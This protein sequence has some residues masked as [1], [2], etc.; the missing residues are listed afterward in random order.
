[1][2][3]DQTSLERLRN[4]TF[5]SSRRG[6][7]KRE[8]EKFLNRLADWLETGGGDEARSDTVRRELE[9]VGQRTGAILS[10]AEES[11]Q[12]IR[13][14][15]EEEA[16]ATTPRAKDAADTT[17]KEAEGYASDSRTAADK[18]S[19]QTRRDADGYAENTR[20]ASDEQA[21]SIK[22][23]SEDE[24]RERVETAK[25][26]AKRIVEEGVKR[27]RDIEAVISDLVRR[28]DE[29][30]RETERLGDQLTTAVQD[31]KPPAG[32]DPFATPDELDPAHRGEPGA[33][34]DAG[35]EAEVT[36][37]GGGEA[38]SKKKAGSRRRSSGTQVK[39]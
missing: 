35:E 23:K 36:A 1:M 9:R 18:Y 33:A 21:A 12:A 19:D 20:Q 24:A 5:P 27:R 3:V 17:R 38:Q 10:Q 22:A 28:R 32:G 37:E 26:Q 6:Y 4:A 34:A 7:D 39:A 30:L 25:A 8:V 15:A 11:A 31:H 2:S 16:R 14:E 13:Q 29:V